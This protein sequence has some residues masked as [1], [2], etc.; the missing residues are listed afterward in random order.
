[1]AYLALSKEQLSR[2]SHHWLWGLSVDQRDVENFYEMSIALAKDREKLNAIIMQMRKIRSWVWLI[3]VVFGRLI[4]D[5]IDQTII[6]Y[7]VM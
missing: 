7:N 1:M 5:H 6:D 4:Y 3:R 2:F